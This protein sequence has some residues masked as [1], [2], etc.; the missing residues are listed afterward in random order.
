MAKGTGTLNKSLGE[1][2]N[3][4]LAAYSLAPAIVITGLLLAAIVFSASFFFVEIKMGSIILLIFIISI[5]VYAVSKNY[6][7]ATV[8]LMAGLLAAFTVEWTWNKYII[9][10][11]ALLGFLFFILLIGSLRIAA[12]MNRF[13]GKLLYILVEQIIVKLRSN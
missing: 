5:I 3:T 12:K 9:F 10:M 11:L 7:E 4:I 8:A 2:R 6:G 1:F 13:T